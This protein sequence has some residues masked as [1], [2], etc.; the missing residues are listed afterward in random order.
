MNESDRRQRLIS[1]TP[2]LS[3]DEVASRTF[4]KG[5]RGFSETEVRGF[6]RRVSEELAVARAREQ[7][8]EAALDA[9]E[10]QLRAP[11][12][13]SEQELLDALGEETARLLRSAREASDDIRAK[14]E[15][16]AARLVEEAADGAE[17]TR[18]EAEALLASRVSEAEA[19]SAELVA[20]AEGRASST[21]DTAA[22]EAEALVENARRQGR[23]ML[24]EAKSARERVLGDLVR[25]RSLLNSQIEALRGGRDRLLDAYR[26]VKRTF[27]DATEAL[28]QVE[29]RAAV[30]RSASSNEAIDVAAEIAAE[31]EK[32]DI[33]VPGELGDATDTAVPGDADAGGERAPA[34]DTETDV[35]SALADVD[36]LFARLRAGHDDPEPGA[37]RETEATDVVPASATAGTTASGAEVERCSAEEWRARRAKAIDPL[38]PALLKR[39]KRRAQDDQNTLLDS[40]RRHKGRP[41]A[42]QVL[43][44][45]DDARNRWAE[46][47]R[48]PL[49]RAY[50]AGRTAAAASTARSSLT[51]SALAPAAVRPAP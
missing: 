33:A 10:E 49:D 46:V 32:L 11:R 8:L 47:L 23:E 28:Q 21:L 12:P 13:L 22:A 35:A 19:K 26:T 48:D 3:V 1:S 7:E 43:S 14:A 20:A 44:D 6:L 42:Q 4:A 25:R 34:E 51:R 16:R 40:V 2:R 38:L 27:L 15:E 29:A 5:V 36:T 41:S 9:L 37:G 30:E 17:R 18:T 24:D 31:I 45:S 50:G 39:A